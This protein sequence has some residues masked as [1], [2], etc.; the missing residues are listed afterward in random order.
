MAM[1]EFSPVC[2]IMK[3]LLIT[4]IFSNSSFLYV[5]CKVYCNQKKIDMFME[6]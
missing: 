4:R 1:K 5:I 3:I 2:D 6:I